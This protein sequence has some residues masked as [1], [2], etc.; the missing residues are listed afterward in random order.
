MSQ[1]K[2]HETVNVQVAMTSKPEKEYERIVKAKTVSVNRPIEEI[3]SFFEE[4]E[5][6]GECVKVVYYAKFARQTFPVPLF[7]EDGKRMLLRDERTG[8]A[9]IIGGEYKYR[10]KDESFDPVSPA[11]T[12]KKDCLSIKQVVSDEQGRFT[13]YQKEM[14]KVLEEK[15]DDGK[16]Y[17]LREDTHKQETNPAAYEVEQKMRA[18][19]KENSAL[20]QNL[21]TMVDQAV[22]K[23]VE[24]VNEQAENEIARLKADYEKQI[25]DLQAPGKEPDAK[26]AKAKTKRG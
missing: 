2:N 22:E 3:D 23:A 16:T 10:D 6:R 9:R 13:P 4:C 7:D 24:A 17:I 19:E 8:A 11:R 1:E 20:K 15:S 5:K 18:M 21:G 12:A 14:I 25:Q 26:P